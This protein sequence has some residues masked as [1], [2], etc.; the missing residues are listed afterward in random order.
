MIGVFFYTMS[1]PMVMMANF[2]YFVDLSKISSQ[3]SEKVRKELSFLDIK[4][5]SIKQDINQSLNIMF[6]KKYHPVGESVDYSDVWRE[7]V[8]L[9]AHILPLACL[10]LDMMINKIKI[11]MGHFWFVIL[12]NAI[13]LATTFFFQ[14]NHGFPVY[15]NNLN[16]FCDKNMSYLYNKEDKQIYKTLRETPCEDKES[17]YA[18][19]YTCV[20][21]H[22]NYFCPDSMLDD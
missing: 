21:M 18:A 22:K 3:F 16:W 1:W 2:F 11:K 7:R 5:Q 8:V 15:L 6:E 19:I 12:I 9:Y 14:L 20:N 17:K 4:H 13:Y 10:L